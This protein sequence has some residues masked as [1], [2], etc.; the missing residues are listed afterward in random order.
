VAGKGV[1]LSSVKS[2]IEMYSGTIWVESKFG[3][4]STFFFTI[5]GKYVGEGSDAAAAVTEQPMLQAA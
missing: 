3:E 1:G 2:I 4:G 5:N